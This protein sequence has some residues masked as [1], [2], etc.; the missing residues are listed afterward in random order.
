MIKSGDKSSSVKRL[1]FTR[2]TNLLPSALRSPF[3]SPK[4]SA[5]H[6][7]QHDKVGPVAH[8]SEVLPHV[9][10]ANHEQLQKLNSPESTA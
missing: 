6:D 10:S 4:S 1:M 5:P 2:A 9:L 7:E 8:F 3:D